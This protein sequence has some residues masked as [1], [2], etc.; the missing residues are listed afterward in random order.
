MTHECTLFCPSPVQ[1]CLYPNM[2]VSLTIEFQKDTP[3]TGVQT[4]HRLVKAEGGQ[5]AP[6]WIAQNFAKLMDCEATTPDLF[7][8]RVF[9]S[10]LGASTPCPCHSYGCESCLTFHYFILRTYL[11]H[12]WSAQF[13]IIIRCT[14]VVNQANHSCA[15]S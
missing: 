1:E 3:A 14:V 13:P 4:K 2:R 8:R 7:E 9:A 15:T 10:V 5:A 12:K 6:G 11:I